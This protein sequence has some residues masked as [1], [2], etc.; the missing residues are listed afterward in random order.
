MT[1][2][3]VLVRHGATDWNWTND[4]SNSDVDYC[5]NQHGS[6]TVVGGLITTNST[7]DGIPAAQAAGTAYI[8]TVPNGW[9]IFYSAL[10]DMPPI[11]GINLIR[12]RNVLRVV[13]DDTQFTITAFP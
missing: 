6:N 11:M 12:I 5:Y 2:Q 8:A 1:V 9:R 4:F 7:Q 13:P 3:I 10:V